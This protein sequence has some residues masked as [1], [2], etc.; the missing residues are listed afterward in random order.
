MSPELKSF[1]LDLR[2]HPLFPQLK[3]AVEYPKFPEYRP[4]KGE[5]LESIGAKAAYAS[6]Q[7]DQHRQWLL[8][9]TGEVPE[10]EINPSDIGD[11]RDR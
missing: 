4:S 10:R 1:L 9:L 11:K 8:V 5:T 7:L 2:Q 3:E 6:G